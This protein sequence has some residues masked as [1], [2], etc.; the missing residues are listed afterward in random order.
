MRDQPSSCKRA[1][2]NAAL[3]SWYMF[4][5]GGLICE[6]TATGVIEVVGSKGSGATRWWGHGTCQHE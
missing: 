3:D 2:G 1:H 5:R 6:P 4:R